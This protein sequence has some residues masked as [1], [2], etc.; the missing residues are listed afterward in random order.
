MHDLD[1]LRFFSYSS[2]EPVI[3]KTVSVT[4]IK[5]HS[6]LCYFSFF[7]KTTILLL[8][9]KNDNPLLAFECNSTDV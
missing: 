5:L 1:N 7:S 4:R 3:F 2:N 8:L 6:T 9:S